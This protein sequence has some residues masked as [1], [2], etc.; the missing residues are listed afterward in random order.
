M[1]TGCFRRSGVSRETR[2]R[3][4]NSQASTA[5]PTS[6]SS[7]LSTWAPNRLKADLPQTRIAL[8]S[9]ASRVA[10]S[11]PSE[12]MAVPGPRWGWWPGR[13]S[14]PLSEC[15]S[16]AL[17]HGPKYRPAQLLALSTEQWWLAFL[18]ILQMLHSVNAV[19]GPTAVSPLTMSRLHLFAG[20]NGA[21]SSP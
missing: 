2:F 6:D 9:W 14:F 17:P 1:R 5:E 20:Q 19:L 10:R 21:Q 13:R 15:N 4:L 12:E 7:S 8:I 18:E 16:V 11:A 3:S